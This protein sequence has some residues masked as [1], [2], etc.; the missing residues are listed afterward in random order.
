[1]E[2]EET[3][4]EFLRDALNTAHFKSVSE[5][6]TESYRQMD[7]RGKVSPLTKHL[8]AA[9]DRANKVLEEAEAIEEEITEE[10]ETDAVSK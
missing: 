6:M 8:Q 7:V 1:M 4:L 10:E 2:I 3:E 9:V 5:D